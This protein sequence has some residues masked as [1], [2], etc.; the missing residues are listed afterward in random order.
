MQD[1]SKK[2]SPTPGDARHTQGRPS[3]AEVDGRDRTATQPVPARDAAPAKAVPDGTAPDAAAPDGAATPLAR[4]ARAWA[5]S[6]G[7]AARNHRAATAAVLLAVALCVAAAVAAGLGLV[8]GP[9]DA[10][11][12]RDAVAHAPAPDWSAGAFDV[13]EDLVA[14][15]AKVRGRSSVAGKLVV[16]ADVTF[17]SGRVRATAPASL[18]YERGASG[19]WRLDVCRLDG[20]ASFAATGGVS[21]ARIRAGVG[22]ILAKAD[23]SAGGGKKSLATLYQ[24][25]DVTIRKSTFDRRRQRQDVRIRLV[26]RHGYQALEC[27]V[28]ASFSFAAASGSWELRKASASKGARRAGLSPV[29]GTW[30]GT[31]QSQ[32]ASGARCFGAQ[33]R[34][35]SITIDALSDDS[36]RMT[37]TLDC[38]AHYHPAPE[39]DVDASDGDES[40]RGVTF[41][42]ERLDPADDPT[43]STYAFELTTPQDARGTITVIVGFGSADDADRAVARVTCSHTSKE[44]FL[45]IP[46]DATAT[47]TDA[48]TLQRS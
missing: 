30:T 37:G 2:A 47:Y 33:G 32:D 22:A 18:T 21:R 6:A 45:L 46:Y 24:D 38:V 28:D 17:Q 15:G 20:A 9:D 48:F 23:S 7:R 3:P 10:R 13:A 4:R 34:T 14:T 5:R 26:R 39:R 16:A 40:V 12:E 1:D 36:R 41:E 29:V 44:S 19:S 11:V 35:L 8:G 25:A 42:G 43:D 31:F 27:D